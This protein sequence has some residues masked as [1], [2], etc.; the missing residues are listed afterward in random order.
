M[1]LTKMLS[2][3]LAYKL[4]KAST[5]QFSHTIK[6]FL[7]QVIKLNIQESNIHGK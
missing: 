3:Q 1:F 5:L 7:S 2:L 6:K 4:S